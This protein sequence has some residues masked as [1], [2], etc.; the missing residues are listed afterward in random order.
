MGNS[1][2]G[3]STMAKRLSADGK[4]PILCLD[5]IAWSQGTTRRPL[6]ESKALLD[7]FIRQHGE[8][9]IEGC[10]ADL[11]EHVLPHC[12]ELRFLNPGIEV[13]IAHGLA[14]P[15]EPEKFE[16]PEAQH[17]A[18]EKL[19]EWVRIY[20][21]RDDEFG[22]MRHRKVF[23]SFQGQKREYRSVCDYP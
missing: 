3:K 14:R 17:A 8:W 20:E 18:L 16:S 22:L 4:L 13:C 6:P 21:I 23:E 2:A 11:I 15:W 9:I 19:L 12:D 10:Y 1:G 7:V 5:E